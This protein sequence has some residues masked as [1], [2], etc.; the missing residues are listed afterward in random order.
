[1]DPTTGI[2]PIKIHH[3]LLPVSCSLRARTARDGDRTAKE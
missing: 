3:P 1:M 2:K